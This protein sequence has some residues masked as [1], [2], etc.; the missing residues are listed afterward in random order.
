[1]VLDENG[2]IYQDKTNIPDGNT[3]N[4][5]LGQHFIIE[6]G[7]EEKP[8]SKKFTLVIWLSNIED[9]DQSS[10]DAGGTFE[11]KVKY[12]SVSGLE[13]TGTIDGMENDTETTSQVGGGL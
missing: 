1:M 7:T 13:L 11:A 8:A 2:N 4:L 5:P 12:T 10:Y 9:E 3:I 6:D